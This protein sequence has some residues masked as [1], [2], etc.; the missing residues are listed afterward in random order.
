MF[1]NSAIYYYFA[2]TTTSGNIFFIEYEGGIARVKKIY[3][4]TKSKMLTSCSLVGPK[5]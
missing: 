5:K 4:L 3:F 2:T 1:D